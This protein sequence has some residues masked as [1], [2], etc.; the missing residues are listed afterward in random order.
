MIKTVVGKKGVF[1]PFGSEG[2]DQVLE[3]PDLFIASESPLG[4]GFRYPC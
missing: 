1:I 4:Y 2:K 3:S